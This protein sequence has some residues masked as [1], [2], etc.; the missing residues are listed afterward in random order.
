LRQTS[1]NGFFCHQKVEKH[2]PFAI[3]DIN[4]EITQ[5]GAISIRLRLVSGSGLVERP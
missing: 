1:E 5:G 4:A 3:Y 2:R